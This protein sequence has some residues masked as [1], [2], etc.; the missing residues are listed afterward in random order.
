VASP[1]VRVLEY[2][3]V[4]TRDVA[5]GAA[6]T[7]ATANSGTVTT[8]AANEL[9][10][11]A[12]VTTTTTSAGAG[13]TSRIVTGTSDI[14]EDRIVTGVGGVSATAAVSAGTRNWVIQVATF[15]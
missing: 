13:F 14:A 15:K 2:A 8:T 6:G 9:V 12:D 11:G 4:F 5:A 3:G 7:T 1:D 10:F